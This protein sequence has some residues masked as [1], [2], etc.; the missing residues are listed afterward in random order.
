MKLYLLLFLLFAI[1]CRPAPGPKDCSMLRNGMY[2]YTVESTGEKV[3]VVRKDN[4]QLE[5]NSSGGYYHKY[6]IDWIDECEYTLTL[7]ETDKPLTT[8]ADSM[9]TKAVFDVKVTEVQQD[10]FLYSMTVD[11]LDNHYADT[12]WRKKEHRRPVKSAADQRQ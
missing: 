7:L 1:S 3:E 8:L 11:G 9:M 4:I 12:I 10:Y 5:T 2:S 6:R